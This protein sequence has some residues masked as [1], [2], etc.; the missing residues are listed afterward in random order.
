MSLS[1]MSTDDRKRKRLRLRLVA[2]IVTIVTTL[3]IL[4]L[5]GR[6]IQVFVFFYDEAARV[7]SNQ[8]PPAYVKVG[9]SLVFAG[10]VVFAFLL[11]YSA[12]LRL[13]HGRRN[14]R[15]AAVGFLA[16]A[17]WVPWYLI[18][19]RFESQATLVEDSSEWPGCF[20]TNGRAK[21]SY[22]EPAGGDLLVYYGTPQTNPG[23]RALGPVTAEICDRALAE[24]NRRNKSATLGKPSVELAS[25]ETFPGTR[26]IELPEIT[27]NWTVSSFFSGSQD[28]KAKIRVQSISGEP[29]WLF[30][31]AKVT[32]QISLCNKGET[33]IEERETIYIWYVPDK[34][35]RTIY[36]SYSLPV[37]TTEACTS[38]SS[39]VEVGTDPNVEDMVG[40]FYFST[41]AKFQVKLHFPDNDRSN[42]AALVSGSREHLGQGEGSLDQLA[43][44][45]A[46]K[47]TPAS[48]TRPAVVMEDERV[49]RLRFK[50]GIT[51]DADDTHY[52]ANVAE[53][54][55]KFQ[56]SA[57]LK[58]TGVL[59]E[60]TV[61]AIN[62]PNA[63]TG[64]ATPSSNAEARRSAAQQSSADRQIAASQMPTS[65]PPDTE[66]VIP[67]V[68]P[69]QILPRAP[70]SNLGPGSFYLTYGKAGYIF[71]QQV[72]FAPTTPAHWDIHVISGSVII[73]RP[74]ARPDEPSWLILAGE[75][76]QLHD[77]WEIICSDCPAR[78]QTYQ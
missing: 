46:L 54:V 13:L 7:L 64:S 40:T 72:W 60:M 45:P 18:Q 62:G 14:F 48:G 9:A 43:D 2:A 70:R 16:L 35:D 42:D 65:Q 75:S 12:I 56:E 21:L 11:P 22:Y 71:A 33:R 59:D 58:P 66:I 73:T 38:L 15:T 61:K 74:D 23:G 6:A 27:L 69:P 55:R 26:K 67:Q 8:L 34:A 31:K 49:P 52:D 19:A 41:D 36:W 78:V 51:E 50:L 3:L 17:M 39:K 68:S 29:S 20:E 25:R 32:L 76:Y 53:A 37:L 30:G 5:Q 63:T 57:K 44:G 77:N 28:R 47:F 4:L 1:P 10:Y 24:R